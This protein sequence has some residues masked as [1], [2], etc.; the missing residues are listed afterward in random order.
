MSVIPSQYRFSA[1]KAWGSFS[2]NKQRIVGD[3]PRPAKTARVDL[4]T[5]IARAKE[6][7]LRLGST[8]C[9]GPAKQST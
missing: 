5:S 2:T 9:H 7:S 6:V 8:D 3:L 4:N 1:E